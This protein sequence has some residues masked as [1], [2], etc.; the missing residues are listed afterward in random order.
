MVPPRIYLLACDVLKAE[1]ELL[2]AGATHIVQTHYLPMG[3]HD[4][5]AILRSE[6]Q[7]CLSIAEFMPDVE[8]VVLMFGLCGNGTAGLV[9]RRVPLVLPRAHDC[10]TLYLGSRER[11]AAYH[12]AHPDAYFYT[13]GW[14]DGKRT[15]GPERLESLRMEFSARFD[16]PDDVEYLLDLERDMWRRRGRAAYID[17]G[18]RDDSQYRQQ[19]AHCT[20]WLGWQ[21]ETLAGDPTLIR[22]TLAGRW[23]DA[24]HLIVQPGQVVR[25][26]GDERIV[27]ADH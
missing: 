4:Q 13:P 3:L 1:L 7:A 16:D 24:R 23:D 10:I 17:L 18:L 5:P 27:T 12:Q 19:L 8:A 14:M 20:H 21:S 26:S 11:Y 25:P 15:P 2:T 22:D 6:L 9:P